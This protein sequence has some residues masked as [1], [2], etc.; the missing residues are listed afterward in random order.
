MTH[1]L[2]LQ[3]KIRFFFLLSSFLLGFSS[4]GYTQTI[5]NSGWQP[6]LNTAT[7]PTPESTSA[8]DDS[9][10]EQFIDRGLE[11]LEDKIDRALHKE[12]LTNTL[13][14]AMISVAAT[15]HPVGAL[16]GGIASAM[17][18]PPPEP[19]DKLIAKAP[20][21]LF[22]ELDQQLIADNNTGNSYNLNHVRRQPFDRAPAVAAQQLAA[23]NPLPQNPSNCQG[24]HLDDRR[25]R[26]RSINNCFYYMA[27]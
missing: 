9:K 4:L 3:Q 27:Q 23:L 1:K 26:Q 22:G 19:T 2:T 11:N 6:G 12:T 13:V 21:D 8:D 7:K 25:S 16:L 17:I 15:A 18:G 24:S 14:G 20:D 5:S 10:L